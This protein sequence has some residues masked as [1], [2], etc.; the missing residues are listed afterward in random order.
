[1]HVGVGTQP[2]R[3]GDSKRRRSSVVGGD[4]AAA[5]IAAQISDPNRAVGG[6]YT[7]ASNELHPTKDRCGLFGCLFGCL[8]VCLAGCL[9]VCLFV[10]VSGFDTFKAINFWLASSCRESIRDRCCH[11]CTARE[12][13]VVTLHFVLKGTTLSQMHLML[14]RYTLPQI[15]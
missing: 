10:C 11:K 4:S 1:M 6:T 15:H 5:A 7:T 2:E 9:V 8:F 13:E 12:R 14:E 3:P